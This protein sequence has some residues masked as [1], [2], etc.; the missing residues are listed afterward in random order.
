MIARSIS[1]SIEG[2]M[3]DRIV[4]TASAAPR[5]VA[6]LATRVDLAP[7]AG[8]SRRIARVTMP[9]VPSLPTNSL[10]SDRPATSLIRLPPRVIRVP[11]A[12]TT[13]RPRT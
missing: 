3:V 8:T 12:R 1:S 4:T 9:S 10:S 11:S 2:R 6:K 13:S 7:W 5:T